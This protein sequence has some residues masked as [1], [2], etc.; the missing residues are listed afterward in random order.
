VVLLEWSACWLALLIA[1][2][3]SQVTV[4]YT[5]LRFDH[6]VAVGISIYIGIGTIIHIL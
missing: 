3:F 1:S 4:H 2:L 6:G 5:A